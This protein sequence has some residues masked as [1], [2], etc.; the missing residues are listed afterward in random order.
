MLLAILL[1]PVLRSKKASNTT[2]PPVLSIV[3]SDLAYTVKMDRNDSILKQLDNPMAYNQIP[4][5]SK[6]KLILLLSVAKLAES[7]DSKEV[8]LIMFIQPLF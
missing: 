8:L 6:S 7:V 4:V 2:R 5:Y 1:L 3:G